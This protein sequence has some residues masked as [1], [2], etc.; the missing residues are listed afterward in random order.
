M[1]D[2]PDV[3]RLQLPELPA[4]LS[5]GMDKGYTGEEL[6]V[7]KRFSHTP[8]KLCLK[9]FILWNY[10]L[11]SDERTNHFQIVLKLNYNI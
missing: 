7:S 8:L 9:L 3:F 1:W 6:G 11:F 5:D 2:L 10:N 4:E